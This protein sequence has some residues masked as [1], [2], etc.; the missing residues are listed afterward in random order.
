VQ[1]LVNQRAD[2]QLN[3]RPPLQPCKRNSIDAGAA[4]CFGD[5]RS[6]GILAGRKLN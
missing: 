6:V 2:K 3:E 5:R 4:L 1:L